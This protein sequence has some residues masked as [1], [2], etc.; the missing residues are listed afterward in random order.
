MSTNNANDLDFDSCLSVLQQIKNGEY[1]VPPSKLDEFKT[2]VTKLYKNARKEQRKVQHQQRTE[3]DRDAVFTSTIS[4]QALANKTTFTLAS[5][6]QEPITPHA[7]LKPKSC[8]CCYQKFTIVHHFYHK[9]CPACAAINF[10]K[11]SARANLKGRVAIITGGRV[12]VGFATALKLLRD[13]AKVIVTTRFPHLALDSYQQETD[14]ADWKDQLVIYGLDL[15]YFDQ[16]NQ[17]IQYIKEHEKHLDILINNAAQT[18]KYPSTYYTPLLSQESQLAKSLPSHQ[19]KYIHS[20]HYHP[21]VENATINKQ[22]LLSIP[23]NR[24]N[25]P[26]DDRPHNSWVSKLDEIDTE[27]LVEV[28]L[29]NNI[30]PFI[31]N[32]QL[33]PLFEASPFLRRYIINV[34][35]SEGQ[36]AYA[37]KKP[38]HPHT[39]MTKAALNMMTRTSAI[40]YAEKQIYMSS[41]DVGWVSTGIPEHKR[42]EL[43]EQGKIPPLDPV[44]SAARIYHPIISGEQGEPLFGS[45]LKDYQT[46]SW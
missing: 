31:L 39:N 16:I 6:P 2:L 11:R 15:R 32:S 21:L 26:V 36:F 25:Q 4:Q 23:L 13:G 22:S 42:K 20:S 1:E 3:E 45:L 43:F 7:Y 44:D 10:D 27:E 9:L 24:F 28:N 37:N 5:S 35:S 29:I 40:D 8:Y 18:I 19:L 38:D 14:Y 34:T 46:V 41:V 12:K 17:F 30:A 33:K